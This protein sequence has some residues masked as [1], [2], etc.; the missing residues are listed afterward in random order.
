M[1]SKLDLT[2]LN[3]FNVKTIK[4]T[5][6]SLGMA[7]FLIGYNLLYFT[8]LIFQSPEIEPYQYMAYQSAY[9]II[10]AGSIM[11][12]VKAPVSIWSLM[13]RWSFFTLIS[14]IIM[15]CI[16]FL[17]HVPIIYLDR[18]IYIF[19]SL[20]LVS[21]I[22]LNLK[23]LRW[24]WITLIFHTAIGTFYSLYWVFTNDV[25]LRTMIRSTTGF[26]FIAQVSY[27]TSFLFFGLLLSPP[28]K[29]K[30]LIFASLMVTA[31]IN[32]FVSFS[33]CYT[34]IPVCKN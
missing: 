6:P 2:W 27:A 7:I 33:S 19:S 8:P 3:I 24:V 9:I 12:L 31:Y 18:R 10:L 32:G 14:I 26:D 29:V 11:E 25:W 20:I 30:V 13:P 17:N 34:D 5:F 1:A 23:N 16:G 15:S 22:G 28:R 4:L 21:N